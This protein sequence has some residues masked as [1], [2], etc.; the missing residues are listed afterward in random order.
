MSSCYCLEYV[1]KW[2]HAMRT[3]CLICDVELMSDISVTLHH[4]SKHQRQAEDEGARCVK[5]SVC[6]LRTLTETLRCMTQQMT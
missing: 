6:S 4:Q 5:Q 2:M 1:F 3:S